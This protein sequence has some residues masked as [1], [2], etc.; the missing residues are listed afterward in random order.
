MKANWHFL[1]VILFGE[2]GVALSNHPKNIIP[3][4]TFGGGSIMVWVSF[5][6]TS[7]GRL[8]ITEGRMNREVFRDICDKN[9][10]PSSIIKR[11]NE[12]RGDISARQ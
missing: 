3:T 10:L 4:L 8:Q 1:A 11:K 9:L 2:T 7:T 5:S 12:K 6:G